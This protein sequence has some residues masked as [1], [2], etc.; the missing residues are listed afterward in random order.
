M[1]ALRLL[2]LVGVVLAGMPALADAGRPKVGLVLSGG[3]AKGMA[4]VGVLRVLEELKIPV[5]I[6]VG[7]SAGSAVGA[8]YASGMNVHEIEERFIDMDWVSSFR[9][10]PGR[11]YKP[12]RRKSQDWR[13]PVAPGLGVRT[14]GL[15]LG[16]GL[17]AGQNLGFILNELTRSASLVEDFDKLA[18]PFRA[19]ATDLET[20]EQVVIGK[21]NLSEAIRA[22]MSVPGVY[23]PVTLDGRLL[24]D[25]GV[26]NNLPVS[27]ARDLGAEIIIA[28]DIT[29]PLL[30]R[31]EIREAFSVVGQLT[32]MMTRQN[33]ERQLK[34]LTDR[35]ILIRPDL[36][37]LSSSDFYEALAL[38]ELGASGARK[39]AGEL[40]HLSVS[41]EQWN[42]YRSRVLGHSFSPGL[43]TGVRFDDH[44][45]LGGSFLR[46]RI[47]Q[48]TGEP[49][50]M[51][52]LEEDLKRIYGLGYYE[53]V[54]YSLVPSE[55]G[56]TD[57]V[58]QVREKSWGP[59][60]LAF[61]LNY[62][63]NFENETRFNL[64]ASLRM[65]GL[66]SL[67]GEWATGVQLGTQPWVRTEW[68]QPLDYGFK[69][70]LTV[71][72]EYSR[73]SLSAF[74]G[75]GERIT[76]VDI[77]SRQVD[78]SLGTELGVNGE[79]RLE[80]QRGDATV[81]EQ[82]GQPVAPSDSI[83]SGSFSLRLVHDSLDDTFL[84]ESGGFAGIRGRFER[85]GLGS[86]RNFDSVRV[87][88]LGTASWHKTSLTGLLFAN[89]VT[90]GVAGIEN[91]VLLGGFRRL[92]AYSQGEVAGEDAVLASVFAR[93]EFGGPFVPWFAG[94]GFESGNAWSSLGDARWNNLLHSASVFAGVESFLG[95]L[96]I[97]TAYNNEDDWSAYLSLGFSFTRLFD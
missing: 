89:T 40:R 63:D 32:T 95:P 46:Q 75:D 94:V 88:A 18:I 33:T 47:R 28:V 61:G 59:N 65:T 16:G 77:T 24:V 82:V 69:R 70:F 7:T 80:Y 55:T 78:L 36:E 68:F 19:V 15:H 62:E 6:V 39:H 87:M 44:S 71:G 50:D 96:Q 85:P 67:G 29:D 10:D 35:D 76:E 51:N 1:S 72:G 23:A 5:D 81:D 64:A 49:L 14:D 34:L 90:R 66:N 79:I 60:Y 26:A 4:H 56:G 41:D 57:L 11:A 21:G 31:D 2:V 83:Q 3:G 30:E 17:I 52:A 13:F 9:D 25:G 53:T 43:I 42:R 86:D 22:S 37:G 38:F 97:A 92:S 91:S 93:Q 73:E 74:D 45:R 48:E 12:V 54:S 8:L 20:G 84:P 58:I 27:V